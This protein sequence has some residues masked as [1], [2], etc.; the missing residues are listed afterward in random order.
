MNFYSARDLRTNTK[1][2]WE[3]LSSGEE[4]VVTRNGRPAALMIDIPEGAFDEVVQ[5]ARQ[6]KA[7][8]ALNSMRCKAAKTDLS[9]ISPTV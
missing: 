9:S 5:A 4:I 6:T 3:D 2:I 1:D 8:I 7:M